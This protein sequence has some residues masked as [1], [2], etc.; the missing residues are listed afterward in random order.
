VFVPVLLEEK[1]GV[2]TLY[3]QGAESA[4]DPATTVV[5][6]PAEGSLQTAASIVT[7][8]RP[9]GSTVGPAKPITTTKLV[10]TTKAPGTTKP[11]GTAAAI[12]TTKKPTSTTEDAYQKQKD[13]INSSNMTK[14]EKAAALKLLSYKMDENG[15]FYVEHQPWQ[16]EFGFNLSYDVAAPFLQL[17]YGTVRVK[18]RYGYVYKYYK[19]GDKKGQV[20]YDENN[21]PIYETDSAGNPI[22]KDWMIQMWKG[23]YGLLIL[24]GEIG[25]YTKASTQKAEHYYSALAEE[26]LIMAMDIY[27]H[28]F[29]T[30]KTKYLFTRGPESAW[31]LTGFVYGNFNDNKSNNKGKDEI[32]MVANVQCPDQEFLNLF[33]NGLSGAG[34]SSGSPGRQNPETYTTSGTSLKFCWQFIDQDK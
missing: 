21:Q 31:W 34:F 26:E 14:E 12:P 27:Q 11:L 29:S 1:D 4:D 5:A 3:A 16:K 30:G 24:G 32:I 25:V 8:K 10:T 20:M 33:A 13:T 22:P 15:I 2:R 28:N 18:F 19:D 17:V 6:P 7:T 9:A 23:R